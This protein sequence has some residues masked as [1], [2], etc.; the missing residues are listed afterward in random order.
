[1]IMYAVAVVLRLCQLD[2]FLPWQKAGFKP[3]MRTWL[4]AIGSIACFQ[5]SA[6]VYAGVAAQTCD[7]LRKFVKLLPCKPD[8]CLP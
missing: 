3:S 8:D 1:M 5:P 6:L 7:C 4:G 2:L